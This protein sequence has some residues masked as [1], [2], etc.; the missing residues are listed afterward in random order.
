MQLTC[1]LHVISETIVLKC[2]FYRDF[3]DL[4]ETGTAKKFRVC[5]HL[6]F[7][8]TC[9]NRER[10]R[11]LLA[12]SGSTHISLYLLTTCIC[13]KTYTQK[14]C[15]SEKQGRNRYFCVR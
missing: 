13:F 1:V 9:I 11:T 7:V 15:H 14:L 5:G 3:E 2:K 8:G 10:K 6:G 12:P 4:I